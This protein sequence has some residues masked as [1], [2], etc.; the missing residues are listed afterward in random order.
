MPKY[1]VNID[2]VDCREA[3][4]KVTDHWT[5]VER[6]YVNRYGYSR[7]AEHNEGEGRAAWRGRSGQDVHRPEIRGEQI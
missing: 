3:D 1:N 5:G 7:G 6:V 2:C 4:V